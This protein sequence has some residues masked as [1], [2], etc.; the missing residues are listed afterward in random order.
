M[1]KKVQFKD[2]QNSYDEFVLSP[3]NYVNT[4]TPSNTMVDLGIQTKKR[5]K[6]K[7]EKEVIE[8][9]ID[10]TMTAQFH[11]VDVEECLDWVK[12]ENN[13]FDFYY[14]SDL[15][16]KGY[17]YLS[18]DGNHRTQLLWKYSN[19][20]NINDFWRSKFRVILYKNLTLNQ[21]NELAKRLN[22]GVGW[23]LIELRN[24]MSKVSEFIRTN[25]D[26]FITLLKKFAG[27]DIKELKRFKEQETLES[28]LLI[29]IQYVNKE[30]Y[31]TKNKQ[32]ENLRNLNLEDSLLKN[33]TTVISI[34]EKLLTVHV[35][36][37]NR[38]NQM[39]YVMLYILSIEFLEKTKKFPTKEEIILIVDKFNTICINIIQTPHLSGPKTLFDLTVRKSWDKLSERFEYIKN[40][41]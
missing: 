7:H 40:N 6:K 28:F 3:V 29:H 21:I 33:N 38:L 14:F 5:W 8:S 27:G 22:K 11:I 10:G 13:L 23:N 34:F 1:N 35:S 39:F 37:Y 36:N 32:K 24:N 4:Y 12:K 41:I 19:D 20:S 15:K 31:E 9:L 26:K 16:N 18:I 2:F 25:S 30:K 17:K